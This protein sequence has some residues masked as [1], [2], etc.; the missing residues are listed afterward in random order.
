MLKV[1]KWKASIGI[2]L[3]VFA[4]AL[5]GCSSNSGSSS[6]SQ[7][8]QS[9]AGSAAPS[10]DN[11]S[12]RTLTVMVRSYANTSEKDQWE[13]V[14]AAFEAQNKDIRVVLSPGDIT[15]E[16]GKLTTMLNSGVTP[17][18]AILMSA[19]PARVGVLS[20]ADLILPMN[21]L[22]EKYNWKDQ[23]LPFAYEMA[24]MKETIYELPHSVDFI[25][26]A[27]NEKIF[28]EIGMPFPATKEQFYP[29]MDKLTEAGYTPL[30]LGVRGGF[31]SSWLF[32]QILE[33]VAGTENMEKLF[34]GEAKWTDP[35]Y[36]EA[37]ELLKEWVDKGVIAKESVSL[38]ADDQ[39]AMFL[40]NKA[41]FLTVFPYYIGDFVQN[42]S[43]DSTGITLLPSFTEG[44]TVKPTG[45]LGYTWVIPKKAENV[46]L[47]ERWLNF[48]MTDYTKIMFED[49]TS[50]LIPANK[51]AFETTPASPMMAAM[52][53]AL[54]NGTGYNPTVYIGNNTK[55]AYLQSLQGLIG[56]MIT[57]QEAMKNTEEGRLK[58]VAEG[59]KLRE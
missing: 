10:G 36:V 27:Y 39:K 54:K 22:Y 21:E 6:P 52:V 1:G 41:A 50:N 11:A 29:T 26:I 35:P 42:N 40:Q 20:N 30:A 51:T 56:G 15:V 24:T 59:F 25:G 46:D 9:P 53:D 32:G 2:A 5:A 38:T 31:A 19:G 4:L 14:A 33:A 45:G 8:S 16:S 47:V 48:I 3:L 34:F 43:A 58:D 17:P 28:D 13:K 37:A 12:E 44:L 57:P 23:L 49:P 55:E 18:D 7:A